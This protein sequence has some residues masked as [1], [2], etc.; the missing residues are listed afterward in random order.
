MLLIIVGFL[1]VGI[2][3]ITLLDTVR[4]EDNIS[5]I[6]TIGIAFIFLV[7]CSYCFVRKFFQTKK[8]KFSLLKKKGEDLPEG[9]YDKSQN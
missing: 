1:I 4:G 2:I 9:E 5:Y 6:I 8:I 3:L 7:S